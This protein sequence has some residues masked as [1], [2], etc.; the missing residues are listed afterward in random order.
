MK[1]VI[2]IA[3]IGLVYSTYALSAQK[4]WERTDE[5]REDH[6]PVHMHMTKMTNR[7]AP[8]GGFQASTFHRHNSVS[9]VF[10]GACNELIT[11][12]VVAGDTRKLDLTRFLETRSGQ[13]LPI[14]EVLDVLQK[15]I[16]QECDDQIEVIRFTFRPAHHTEEDY[17]YEGTMIKTKGWTIEDGRIAT[18][19]DHHHTFE[20]GFRDMFSVAGF[21]Y[22]GGCQEH[23]VL[24]LEPQFANNQ[25]RALAKPVKFYSWGTA[26]KTAAQ[27]YLRECPQTEE[28]KFIINPV[29]Q[30]YQC[31]NEGEDCFLISRKKDEWKVDSSQFD[32][33]V[34]N[35]PIANFEDMVE[36]LAAGAL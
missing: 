25:E 27:L 16:S 7:D 13:D 9:T 3:F 32:L 22:R 33:K 4:I 35:S 6:G 23:P 21:R 28:I 14:K 29:P 31:K 1:K 2:L 17:N 19:F 11:V 10:R 18:A 12:E 24:M 36:V 26:A 20:I 34:Y 30:E 5:I 8:I 15:A